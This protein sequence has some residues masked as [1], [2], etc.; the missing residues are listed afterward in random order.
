MEKL[1][2]FLFITI[3]AGVIT[4]CSTYQYELGTMSTQDQAEKVSLLN[5]QEKKQMRLK[6]KQTRGGEDKGNLLTEADKNSLLRLKES[7]TQVLESMASQNQ[8]KNIRVRSFD[9]YEAA[10]FYQVASADSRSYKSR[11]DSRMNLLLM[12]KSKKRPSHRS[13]DPYSV[14]AQIFLV[15]PKEAKPGFSV[16]EAKV[17]RQVAAVRL[18]AEGKQV[19]PLPMGFYVVQFSRNG[20]IL[21]SGPVTLNPQFQVTIS[22]ED[23]RGVGVPIEKIASYASYT[24]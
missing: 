1:V 7:R 24:P 22:S 16:K 21:G 4:S 14:T 12:N 9:G 11:E 19:I 18:S 15:K 5:K 3:A 20:E 23:A 6:K 17:I 13:T 8:K 2:K 10:Y